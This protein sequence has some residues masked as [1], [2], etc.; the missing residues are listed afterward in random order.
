MIKKPV[1]EQEIID[2]MRHQLRKQASAEQPNL[3]QA[4]ECLHAAMEILEEAG[5]QVQAD[6]VLRVLHKIASD[7]TKH[8]QKM[9]TMQKLLEHG[10]TVKDL[11][12]FGH[13]DPGAKVRM[14]LALRKMGLKEHEIAQLIGKHN[15]VPEHELKTYEKF[16]G[17]IKDPTQVDEGPA[18]PGQTVSM[19]S[20]PQLPEEGATIPAGEEISFKSLASRPR[21]PSRPDK[22]PNGHTKKLT[23]Q[24][25]VEN[26]MHHGTVFNMADDGFDISSADFDPELVE[27]LGVN[28]ADDQLSNDVFDADIDD[29]LEVSDQIQLE[30]FED[31]KTG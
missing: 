8:V 10:M 11:Q 22:V 31:E 9:P 14:N 3:V 27:A 24:K 15:L 4:G 13:G 18:Q 1:F 30:D 21:K 26:L 19:E 16:M 2:G 28:N 29:S 12:D 20:L 25:M 17:W 7:P 6:Q 23:P 5:L